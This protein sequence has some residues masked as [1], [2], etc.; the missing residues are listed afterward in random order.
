MLS[1]SRWCLLKRPELL[2]DAQAVK[3][4]ELMK[5]N[6]RSVRADRLPEDVHRSWEYVG[7]TWAGRFLNE[8]T[9]RVRPSRLEPL[10]K[11]ARTL[12]NHREFILSGFRAAGQRGLGLEFV[13]R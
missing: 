5:Y 13:F 11:V 10:Q 7:P 2:T 4:S 6:L 1:K 8:R 3:P 9:R 12:R